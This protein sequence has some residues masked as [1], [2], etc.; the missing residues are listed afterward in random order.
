MELES[1]LNEMYAIMQ[2]HYADEKP[3]EIYGRI[4]DDLDRILV[5][6]QYNRFTE[7]EMSRED[8]QKVKDFA[9]ND[10]FA[11]Q[12]EAD[13]ETIASAYARIE[14]STAGRYDLRIIMDYWKACRREYGIKAKAEGRER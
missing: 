11:M 12:T 5:V 13:K 10:F 9:V 2:E 3:S 7:E 1:K 4:A 14:R 8:F 6:R